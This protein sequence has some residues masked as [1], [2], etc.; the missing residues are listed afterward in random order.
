DLWKT[1]STRVP[2]DA[3]APGHVLP[4]LFGH[5][6]L[7]HLMEGHQAV[8]SSAVVLVCPDSFQGIRTEPEARAL[9]DWADQRLAARIG[10]ESEFQAPS[11]DAIFEFARGEI[12]V[13]PPSI[14]P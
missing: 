3:F 1:T 8:R 14:A 5:A 10:N 11:A 9:F 7:E 2:L 12:L 13:G 4:L 6:L